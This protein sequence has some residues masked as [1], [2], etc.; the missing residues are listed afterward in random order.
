MSIRNATEEKKNIK[1]LRSWPGCFSFGF[2]AT[3]KAD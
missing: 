2:E 3:R 1:R